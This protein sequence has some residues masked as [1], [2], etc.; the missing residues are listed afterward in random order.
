MK[1]NRGINLGG[2]LSQC[3]HTAEHYES[4]ITEKDI[5][6]IKAAGFDHVRVPVD[7]NVWETEEGEPKESGYALTDRLVKWCEKHGLEVILD[8]HK[9]KGYDFNDANDAEKNNLFTN[10]E[11]QERFVAL[12]TRNAERYGKFPFVAF[13]LLNEV[14]E[15]ENADR[16]NAL[17]KRTVQAIRS[18]APV[19]TVIYGGIQWNN[20]EKVK[21][22]EKPIDENIIFTFHYYS[23]MPFTHQRASWCDVDKNLTAYYPDESQGWTIDYPR[24]VIKDGVEA[25]KRMGVRLYCGEFGVINF[26]PCESTLNWYRDTVTVFREYNIGCSPWTYKSMVFGLWDEHYAPIHDDL[27][28]VLTGK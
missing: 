8:L 13:E 12:W 17:I 11:L 28:K 18:K 4:F 25:A 21:F 10:A 5:E 22:L 7:I 19:S 1:L 6:T 2:W 16:W 26:A 20:V 23:P 24:T 3:R 9:A 27:I 15:S 14:V